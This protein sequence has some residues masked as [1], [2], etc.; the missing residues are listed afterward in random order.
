ME[1]LPS[2]NL[3]KFIFIVMSLTW[4]IHIRVVKSIYIIS[5]VKIKDSVFLFGIYSGLQD[6]YC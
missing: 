2:W 4:I 6:V 3:H 5:T 1:L